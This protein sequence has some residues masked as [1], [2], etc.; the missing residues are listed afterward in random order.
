MR[1][2][3]FH[4]HVGIHLLLCSLYAMRLSFTVRC[5]YVA[6]VTETHLTI[7]YTEICAN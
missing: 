7:S 3:Y 6:D 4:E 1:T 2:I 5:Q